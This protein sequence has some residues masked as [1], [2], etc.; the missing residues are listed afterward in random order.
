MILEE[1]KLQKNVQ[2]RLNVLLERDTRFQSELQYLQVF[3]LKKFQNIIDVEHKERF[4]NWL[5]KAIIEQFHNGFLMVEQYYNDENAYIDDVLFKQPEGMFTENIP[6]ILRE[7]IQPLIEQ[8]ITFDEL[9]VTKTTHELIMWSMEYYEDIRSPLKQMSFDLSCFGAR[10]ALRDKGNSLGYKRIRLETEER[11]LGNIGDLQFVN[12]QMYLTINH[13]S[14]NLEFWDIHYW[15]T[16]L[17]NIKKIGQAIVI[18]E[19]EYLITKTKIS[20]HLQIL[21]SIHR[22]EI[23]QVANSHMA[24]LLHYAEP[25]EIEYNLTLINAFLKQ[26]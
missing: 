7:M 15:S 19:P 18:T 25:F 11:K 9:I 26:E 10:Q 13:A 6:P 12:P 20:Y 14:E 23:D 22:D 8:G 2:D 1:R 5:Q 4:N 17:R 16:N 24:K 3:Y 21:S